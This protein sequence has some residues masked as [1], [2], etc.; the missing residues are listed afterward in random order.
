MLNTLFAAFKSG[1]GFKGVITVLQHVESLA[2][3]GLEA[4]CEGPQAKNDAI[5]AIVKI[6]ESMKTEVT[7]APVVPPVQTP[8][9]VS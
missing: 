4:F 5:D 2:T 8:P 7:V 3:N 9:V 1:S 6:L